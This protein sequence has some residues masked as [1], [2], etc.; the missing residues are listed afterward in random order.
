LAQRAFVGDGA[1]HSCSDIAIAAGMTDAPEFSRP[2]TLDAARR[3][4]AGVVVEADAAERA[5]LAARFDL[6]ALDQL[7]AALQIAVAGD[8][9]NI[10][11][12]LSA[13]VTQRCVATDDPVPAAIETPLILRCVPAA[14]VAEEE[15]EIELSDAACDIIEYDG[16]AIDLG[17]LVAQSLS[18]ALDPW[19]R[20]PNA[21]EVLRAAGIKSEAEAGA[22]GALA[23]LRDKLGG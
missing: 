6:L 21:D 17:E 22:F 23:A 15:A 12:N 9:I 11:G 19:P 1:I 3:T 16:A 10:T 8:E 5:A 20:H 14:P 4:R 18:L 2:L 13:R 7:N